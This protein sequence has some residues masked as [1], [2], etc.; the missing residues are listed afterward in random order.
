MFLLELLLLCPIYFDK[1]CFH[2]LLPWGILWFHFWPIFSFLGAWYLF[3]VCAFPIFSSCNW[4]LVSYH[5]GRK[6]CFELFPDKLLVLL[7]VS[8]FFLVLSNQ[9]N[10]LL[11]S[12][13]LTVSTK[14]G[15]SL[16]LLLKGYPYVGAPLY[17]LCVP[18]GFGERAGSDMSTSHIFPQGVLKASTLVGAASRETRAK[19]KCELELL[20]YSVANTILFGWVPSCW[21]RR[22]KGQ[23]TLRIWAGSLPSKCVL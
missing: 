11:F 12:L 16:P 9:M 15:K 23:K 17:S 2:F 7:V 10:S 20:L 22:P 21:S 19:L 18:S 6:Q 5:C 1:S 3:S 8:G 13:C 4:F 14:I